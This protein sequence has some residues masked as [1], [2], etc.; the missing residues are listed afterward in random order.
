MEKA[1]LPLTLTSYPRPFN[2]Q[3][4]E[5]PDPRCILEPQD[6]LALAPALVC[7]LCCCFGIIYCCLGYRCFKAVMFLSGLLSGALVIFLL[8]HKERVLETQLS[9]EVSAGIALGIGLL[10]GLVTMLVRSVGLFLTGL[11]LGLTLGAGT[12][13]GTEP[14]YRP[15]S[16]WVP[17]GGL[18]GLALL[19]ALLT[20]RWPRPFTVLGTALLGAAVLVACADYF[21]EGLALGTRLGKRL[22]ALP[23]LPPLCWYSWVLLGTWP[24]LGAL[25]TLAQWKLMAEERGSHTNV[26]LSHQQRHLQL[27]RLHQQ[28]SKRHRTPSGTGLCGGRCRNQLPPNI[29]SPAHR[30]A[31]S[32]QQSLRELE[33]VPS[34]QATGPHT[35][36]D[37]DS[38][39]SS[40]V[41]LTTPH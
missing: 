26:I 2:Q 24:I 12:L 35:V 40:T 5:P 23:E 27:L 3:L 20:L 13:L 36:L 31:P 6:S 17:V 38:D 30:P 4:P 29:R 37:L 19:G 18:I 10:C 15:H 1:S 39:C 28:E 34:P 25:G 33:L 14:I 8:C 22:Q 21:L 9:L 7:A 11:L 16:A 41:L 32:Y